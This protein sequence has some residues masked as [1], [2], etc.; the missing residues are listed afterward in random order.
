MPFTIPESSPGPITSPAPWAAPRPRGTDPLA[1]AVAQAHQRGLELHVWFSPF[2]ASPPNGSFPIASNHITRTR[3]DLVR[4]VGSQL[5]L[6]PG[7][8]DVQDYT[9]RVILDV[10]QRYNI[11]G[12]HFDDRLGYPESDPQHRVDFPDAATY[13]RYRSA[14][15]KLARD[16]WRREN[17]NQFVHRVYDSVK[18]AK[19]WVK[20]GIAP[21]G[22]WENGV[23]PQIKGMSS[24][25]ILFTDSRKW[26][27]NGW[28]DYCSP[29]LY[30]PIEHTETSFPVLLNWWRQQNL[31][32]RN[33][34][35]GLNTAKSG[36]PWSPEE[37]I[38]E[39]SITR[40]YCDGAAGEIHFSASALL[41]NRGGIS[42]EL[43]RGVYA[44]PAL[45][46]ASAWLEQTYPARPTLRVEGNRASWE[47]AS[48]S[49]SIAVWLWQ[50]R[51]NDRWQC[52]IL[53]GDTREAILTDSPELVA[54]TAVDRC[55]VA[56]PAVVLQRESGASR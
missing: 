15:G 41:N 10:V 48:A 6:D 30:W 24:D 33:L 22:I 8:R 19:P 29:Q 46:P 35:P 55:G 23:P 12:V 44:S 40:D 14:G 37:I 13:R 36:G 45:V 53:P 50:T 26:L 32:H 16:D 54:L 42:N 43:S 5:W 28:L 11:D 1:F 3:P 20:V 49:N 52:R 27:A 39:I 25:S 2:R 4:K 38:G 56:S 31:M 17:I 47:P 18:A 34:W 7:E 51:A 21:F 9:L